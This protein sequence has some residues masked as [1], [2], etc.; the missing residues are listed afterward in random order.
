MSISQVLKKGYAKVFNEESISCLFVGASVAFGP[1]Y[2]IADAVNPDLS[3][4]RT[5]AIGDRQ[6]EGLDKDLTTILT[7]KK[8]GD[9]IRSTLRQTQQELM[10]NP[11]DM[12]LTAKVDAGRAEEKEVVKEMESLS[13]SFLPRVFV[14]EGISEK[15]AYTLFDKYRDVFGAGGYHALKGLMEHDVARLDECQVKVMTGTSDLNTDTV[16]TIGNC[17]SNSAMGGELTTWSLSLLYLVFAFNGI[18]PELFGLGSRFQ[19]QLRED[20]ENKPQR[21]DT[22]IDEINL[23]VKIE[24]PRL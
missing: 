15:D 13:T 1:V 24:K 10:A 9:D 12:S 16:A 11:A 18:I 21:K 19:R 4:Q 6:Y 2:M 17:M 20:E 3:E 7:L 8:Q 14:S 22:V 23:K 5:S